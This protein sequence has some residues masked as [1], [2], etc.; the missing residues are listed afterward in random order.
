M[1][2]VCSGAMRAQLVGPRSPM[3]VDRFRS[4]AVDGDVHSRRISRPVVTV[5]RNNGDGIGR[6]CR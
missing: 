4:Y 5:N 2:E 1:G 3:R 6:G